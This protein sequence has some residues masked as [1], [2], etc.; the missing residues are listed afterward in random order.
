MGQRLFQDRGQASGGSPSGER[1]RGALSWVLASGWEE[2][3]LLCGFMV[4]ANPNRVGHQKNGM[5][6]KVAGSLE[7]GRE[8]R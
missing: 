1:S 2:G 5:E 8:G 6:K 7:H 4:H 3:R